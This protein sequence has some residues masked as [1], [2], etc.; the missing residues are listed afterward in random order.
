M[1]RQ[2]MPL[3]DAEKVRRDF[4]IF[5]QKVHGKPLIYLDSA[6]TAQKPLVVIE[7][8]RRFYADQYG[9][10]HRAVYDLAAQ[11]TARYHAVRERV[12]VFLGAAHVE[13]IIFTKGTTEAINLVA[14]SFGKAFINAGD[15]V[16]ISEM[17]HHANLLPWQ[18]LCKER[19]ALLK[20]IPI[21][22][23]AELIL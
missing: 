2:P 8:L 22:D 14:S 7:T 10:V 1:Q 23:Q 17:E 9:T 5:A 4:P 13:E 11:S 16:L 21:N 6:A 18:Q 3:F 20:I 19:G 15:E 12:R